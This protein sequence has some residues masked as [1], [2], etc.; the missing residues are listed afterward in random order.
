[1]RLGILSD[2]HDELARTRL[3]VQIMRDA[4]AELLVHC[5]DLASPPIVQTLAVLPSWFVLGNHDA[6]VVPALQ[7][8]A[9]EFGPVCLGWGGVIEFGGRRVGIAHGHMTVDMRRVLAERPDFLLSGHAH[10]PSDQVVGQVR[11]INP[12]SLYRADEFTVAVLDL[13]TGE[14]QLLQVAE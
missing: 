5:G 2:T 13:E 8:A 6:D 11:R 3:A 12:G 4:G 9:I 10:F 7:R 14:L 1:M